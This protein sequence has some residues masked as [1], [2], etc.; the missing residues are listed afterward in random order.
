[1]HI[2]DATYCDRSMCL[3]VGYT[4][5]LCKNNGWTDRD[6][7]WGEGAN[8]RGSKEPCVRLGSRSDESI[9]SCEGVQFGDAAFCQIT[10]GICLFFSSVLFSNVFCQ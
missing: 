9:R 1:M 8:S 4:D 6:S 5:V 2:I 10:L 7:V 3:Y